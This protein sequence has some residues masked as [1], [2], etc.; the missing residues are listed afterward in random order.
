MG[1]MCPQTFKVSKPCLRRLCFNINHPP[2]HTHILPTPYKHTHTQILCVLKLNLSRLSNYKILPI[3]NS[4][5]QIFLF[6]SS[7]FFLLSC[8]PALPRTS[9][10]FC[11][12]V[13]EFHP[14]QVTP[15]D[16][17]PETAA[18]LGCMKPSCSYQLV[19]CLD[20]KWI[21]EQSPS[22]LRNTRNTPTIC[23]LQD[24]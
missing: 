11:L 21:S 22:L 18:D 12:P 13:G 15:P 1:Q 17:N 23:R 4:S 3:Q 19:H 14:V 10:K 5:K 20:R 6:P 9:S 24:F 2:P 16:G 8:I 7:F